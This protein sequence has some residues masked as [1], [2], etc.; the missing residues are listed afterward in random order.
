MP[1]DKKLPVVIWSYW[2]WWSVSLYTQ[3]PA[4]LQVRNIVTRH[5]GR[6]GT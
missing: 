1:S 3:I 5:L 6:Q 4:S 2:H